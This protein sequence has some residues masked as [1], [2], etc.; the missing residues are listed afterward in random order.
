MTEFMGEMERNAELLVEFTNLT[1]NRPRQGHNPAH[2]T[3]KFAEVS[4]FKTWLICPNLH[5]SFGSVT[6]VS[7]LAQICR[8]NLQLQI[9]RA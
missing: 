6:L 5:A 1:Q 9:T 2:L 8:A 4:S 3:E 7:K